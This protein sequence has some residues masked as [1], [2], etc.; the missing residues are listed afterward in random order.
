MWP[1]IFGSIKQSLTFDLYFMPRYN[2]QNHNSNF[3]T[4]KPTLPMHCGK[5]QLIC[6]LNQVTSVCRLSIFS[7]MSP[8][9][10]A[11]THCKSYLGFACCYKIMS[12]S[13]N[14]E[15]IIK[16]LRS[17]IHYCSLCFVLQTRKHVFYDFL[18]P[19]RSLPVP[20]FTFTLNFILVFF[21][22]IDKYNAFMSATC[23]FFKKVTL[24]K[25]KNT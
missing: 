3:P 6:Y 1:F 20:F 13:W 9:L 16:M 10:L 19:I 7:T 5:A 17:F 24:I 15:G 14:I 25:G 8:N 4:S 11:I 2:A 23:K 22:I 18:Q 12:R 21:F